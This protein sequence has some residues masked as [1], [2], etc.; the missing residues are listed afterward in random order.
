MKKKA[1]L[2]LVPFIVVSYLLHND[3]R[4]YSYKNH[5]TD[6][7]LADVGYNLFAVTLM[8]LLSWTGAFKFSKNKFLDILIITGTYV[9]VEIVSYFIPLFGVF[10]IKDVIALLFSGTLTLCLFRFFDKE[11]FEKSRVALKQYF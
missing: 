7:G 5:I 11:A 4:A 8:A 1:V 9:F 6:F 10:D 2:F 3:Y